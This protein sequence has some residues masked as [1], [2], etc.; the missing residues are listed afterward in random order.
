M[1]TFIMTSLVAG[2]LLF[3]SGCSTDDIKDAIAEAANTAMVYV[4]NGTAGDITVSV[5]TENDKVVAS[6]NL[7][8]EAFALDGRSSYSVSY[9]GAHGT[10]FSDSAKAYLYAATNCNAD[11]FVRDQADGNRV[12]VVN[13]TAS[14]FTKDILVVDANGVTYTISDNSPKCSAR[15]TS[16]LNN[17]KVGNGMKVKIGDGNWI[18]IPNIDP[19]LADL[20]NSIKVDIV[21]YSTADGTIVPMA[22]WDDLL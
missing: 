5:Q 11:G 15:S 7:E 2:S 14:T 22:N 17:I 16:Q 21:V 3:W 18:N 9:D 13:L 6:H 20:A 4:V 19:D 10:N 8:A 12:H 1:K